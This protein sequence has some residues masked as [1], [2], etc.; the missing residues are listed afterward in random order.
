MEQ[1]K[2]GAYKAIG[3]Q[4]DESL[5]VAYAADPV[6]LES[7]SPVPVED[8][9]MASK[10]AYFRDNLD[11]QLAVFDYD[12]ESLQRNYKSDAVDVLLYRIIVPGIFL[13]LLLGDDKALLLL[14]LSV[15]VVNA[16]ILFR[17]AL[18]GA[19]KETPHTA[20]TRTGLHHVQPS[21][22]GGG[23]RVQG[24]GTMLIPFSE[25]QDIAVSRHNVANRLPLLLVQIKTR[26]ADGTEYIRGGFPTLETTDEG[27]ARLDL[28]GIVNPFQL[29]RLL[30]AMKDQACDDTVR[31]AKE[32][33]QDEDTESSCLR[34]LRDELEKQIE[35]IESSKKRGE[36]D[37]V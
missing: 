2:R 15:I 34:E 14:F 31:R 16:L 7:S 30:L 19:T 8:G 13:S 18:F 24:G 20:V 23:S 6:L 22:S 1:R 5:P 25:I 3:R 29:K 32:A 12:T 9:L 33:L 27:V 10:D 37:V 21:I 26:S 17:R 28:L 11:D 36:E 4:Q 35:M